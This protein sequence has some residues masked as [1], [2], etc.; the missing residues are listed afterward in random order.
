M[1]RQVLLNLVQLDL[2]SR[3]PPPP[4]GADVAATRS[5]RRVS[6]IMSA[7]QSA[8][9][10]TAD[11]MRA[12]DVVSWDQGDGL[13][14]VDGVIHSLRMTPGG[15][16][17]KIIFTAPP[18]SIELTEQRALKELSAAP[19][20]SPMRAFLG[21]LAGRVRAAPVKPLSSPCFHCA[22]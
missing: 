9:A 21:A 22:R 5:V 12:G 15:R 14:P 3:L 18:Q 13:P 16:T 1:S 2:E 7:Q 8:M 19:L 20:D 11:G 10:V 6:A 4:S 17:C